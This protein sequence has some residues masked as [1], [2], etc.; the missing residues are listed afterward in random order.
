MPSDTG[1][2]KCKSQDEIKTYYYKTFLMIKNCLKMGE[3][4]KRWVVSFPSLSLFPFPWDSDKSE[5]WSVG[6]HY[7]VALEDIKQL[8][9]APT[10]SSFLWLLQSQ[11]RGCS[12]SRAAFGQCTAPKDIV[13]L[14]ESPEMWIQLEYNWNTMGTVHAA[15]FLKSETG[16][17]TT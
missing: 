13:A 11:K 3:V 7:Q 17:Y 4:G 14:S 10:S 2:G 15:I 16:K 1:C 5:R 12:I 6:C 9:P 8:C